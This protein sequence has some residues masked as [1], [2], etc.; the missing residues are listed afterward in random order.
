MTLLR[1]IRTLL[2]DDTGA[3]AVAFVMIVVSLIV[4]I[5]LVVDSSGKY[6]LAEQAQE[7]ANSAARSA[8]NAISGETVATG[9]LELDTQMATQAA[10]SYLDASGMT[11]SVEVQGTVVSVTTHTTYSTKFLDIIGITS[12]PAN[13]SAS[14]ELITQ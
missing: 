9:S 4:V 12:L 14:A 7:V 1:K 10:Q 5:G 2:R 13:G 11:G 3:A 8:T 6:Q